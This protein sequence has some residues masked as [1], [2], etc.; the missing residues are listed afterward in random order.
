M[1]DGAS[2]RGMAHRWVDVHGLRLHCVEAGAGPLVV[3]LHGFPEFWYAWR[4]QI[5]AVA[6]AG[7]RVVAPNLRGYNTSDKPPRVRDYRP[8]VLARD[9][10]DLVV[11]LGAG[12]AAVVGHDWGGGLA[13][14]LAMQHPERIERLVVLN[15]PHP[16]RLLKGLRNP[17]QLRRSWYMLAFQAP[18]LPERLVAARD[19]RACAGPYASNRPGR[20]PSRLRTSTATRPPPPN[21]APCALPSTTIGPPSEPTRSRRCAACAAWTSR[22]SSFGES[23]TAT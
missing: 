19:F 14:L 6:D 22:P 4:H 13:W 11:A 10:A 21:Q 7:Y 12:S 20:A 23:R 9:V 18:W 1:T 17:R 15:A 2:T 5:P 3:L 8:R 16:I